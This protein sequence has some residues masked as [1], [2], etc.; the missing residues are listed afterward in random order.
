MK[1]SQRKMAR[2]SLGGMLATRQGAL[3]LAL[4][5]AACA[6]GILVFA[7]GQYKTQVQP[8]AAVQATVLVATAQIAQGTAGNVISARGLY[9]STPIAATQV[10]PGAV[11][12][13]SVLAGK[14]AMTNIVA[15]QQ[16]TTADF[17][18]PVGVTGL[19]TPDQRA[20]A[21]NITESPGATD[22]LQAGE[23]VDIYASWGEKMVLLDPNIEVIKPAGA[24]AST[25]TGSAQP[26]SAAP[27]ATTA[28]S[29]SSTTS[30]AA[31]AAAASAAAATTVSGGS[32][33]LAVTSKQAADLVYA[34]QTATLYL[35][36]R[37]NGAAT[38]P[39]Q[40]TTQASVIAD[41]VAQVNANQAGG[42]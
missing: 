42:H 28:A 23:R 26:P 4:I 17:S 15:G 30:A 36:L 41:S 24:T 13:A 19:L 34:A 22:I 18:G 35:T 21:L 11:S 39:S 10:Q 20:V 31:A 38:T 2:P 27:T 12:D 5:C 16:L 32:M 14:V 9:K 1:M 3:V 7:L 29:G 8:P 6:A 25:S 40:V 33:V 37:P